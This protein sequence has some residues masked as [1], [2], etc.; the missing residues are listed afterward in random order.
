VGYIADDDAFVLRGL[1]GE[2]LVTTT[3][4]DLK[5]A[6]KRPFGDLI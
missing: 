5:A 4:A 2:A 3:V 6:W 1:E